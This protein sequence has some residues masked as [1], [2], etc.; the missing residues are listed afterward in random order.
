MEAFGEEWEALNALSEELRSVSDEASLEALF[1]SAAELR[2]AAM[3]TFGVEE[4]ALGLQREIDARLWEAVKRH[5][6]RRAEE[7]MNLA[8]RDPLTGMLNRAAFAERL[9]E[10]AARARRY[11]RE[12]SVAIFDV[13]R[14]KQVNDEQGHVAG[15]ALLRTI[16][17]ALQASLRQSDSVYRYGGDEFV[18][19]YPET[20]AQAIVGALR[21]AEA[22]IAASGAVG[23]S[24]GAASF[25][26][27]AGDEQALLRIA[28]ER[29][30]ENK[31]RK[32]GRAAR[33]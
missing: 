14:F 33:A 12:L 8:R 16:A 6:D 27:D 22:R 7:M 10:E 4:A 24:W 26:A 13:D 23:I 31:R 1:R 30:Y 28:D 5:L 11:E 29:L 2:A 18:A 19:I 17:E 21:R 3:A 32:Q 9:R 20:S 15:D 25:P